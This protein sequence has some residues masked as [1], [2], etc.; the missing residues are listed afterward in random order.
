[1]LNDIYGVMHYP[2]SHCAG[3]GNIMDA[4]V[5]VLHVHIVAFVYSWSWVVKKTDFIKY[6]DNF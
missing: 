4:A 2:I 3:F 5:I 1:M 6:R